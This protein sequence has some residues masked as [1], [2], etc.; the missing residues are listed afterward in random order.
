MGFFDLFK[1]SKNTSAPKATPTQFEIIQVE[2]LMKQLQESVELI[3][4]TTSPRTFFRRLN[5]A[6]DVLLELQKYEK[7]GLFKNSTPTNDYNKILGNLEATVNDF[8]DRVIISQSDKNDQLNTQQEKDKRM[9]KCVENLWN[10]FYEANDYWQG[11]G[12]YPHYTGKLYADSNF[13]RVDDILKDLTTQAIK[14]EISTVSKRISVSSQ[15]SN[16]KTYIPNSY[17]QDSEKSIVD[18][19]GRYDFCQFSTHESSVIKNVLK[20]A[21][22]KY[23]EEIRSVGLANESSS[24]RYKARDVLFDM[25]IVLYAYSDSIIDQF[26]VAMAYETKGAYFRK[27]ALSYFEKVCDKITPDF[28]SQFLYYSP[29]SVYSKFSK[30]YEDEHD[31]EKAIE[32]TKLAWKYGDPNNQ[33]FNNR[34]SLLEAKL[35]DP[36]KKRNTKMSQA[37]IQLENNIR[38]ASN[39]FISELNLHTIPHAEQ[40]RQSELMRRE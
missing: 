24:I 1:K 5:F 34:I 7:Y 15:K 18:E 27:D 30:L 32:L 28:M 20:T 14:E 26:A 8:I 31:Y 16:R 40:Y 6:L 10:S 17:S 4:T 23:P 13:Q 9:K 37:R 25:V 36:P 33:S 22:K 3:N 11:N 19:N 39:N 35:S 2:N 21:Y 29:L 38:Q 12:M